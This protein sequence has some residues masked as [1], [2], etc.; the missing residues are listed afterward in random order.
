LNLTLHVEAS[1]MW[2]I[3]EI[4]LKASMHSSNHVKSNLNMLIEASHESFTDET[5]WNVNMH[6]NDQVN[7]NLT[8]LIETSRMLCI[9]WNHIES[10]HAFQ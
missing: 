2:F 3:N 5:K 7:L 4:K 8:W 10:R 9:A 1:C 6:S